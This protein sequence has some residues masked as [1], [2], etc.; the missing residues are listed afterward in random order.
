MKLTKA[1]YF[2]AFLLAINVF[3][4]GFNNYVEA[5]PANGN[6]LAKKIKNNKAAFLATLI[7]TLALAA[8][9]TTFG[10]MHLKK[11]GKGKKLPSD[12]SKPLFVPRAPPNAEPA[13]KP[14]PANA[15]KA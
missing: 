6:S 1:L 7:T 5:K 13:S 11:K 4:P 15:P 2:I 3:V 8:A 14:A 10:V 12:K 9:G